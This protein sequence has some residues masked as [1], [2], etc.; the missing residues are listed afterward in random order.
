MGAEIDRESESALAS[1]PFSGEE[2]LLQR[3][4]NYSR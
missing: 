3:G 2:P 4:S 1:I